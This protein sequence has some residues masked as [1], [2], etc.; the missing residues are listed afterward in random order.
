MELMERLL[1]MK[2][3]IVVMAVVVAMEVVSVSC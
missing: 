2:V 3:A 1:I